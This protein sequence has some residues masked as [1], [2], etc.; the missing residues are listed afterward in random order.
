MKETHP[1]KIFINFL[2][3]AV[4]SY[5]VLYSLK[6]L[7]KVPLWKLNLCGSEYASEKQENMR[8]ENGDGRK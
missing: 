2:P 6:Y 3:I 7:V 8:L 5:H 1:F 4:H